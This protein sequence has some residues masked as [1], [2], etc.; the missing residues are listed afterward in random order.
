MTDKYKDAL[1]QAQEE[2]SRLEERRTTLIRLI[3]N[4]KEL[5]GNDAYELTP[6]PGYTPKGL[7]EE[8]RAILALTTVPLEPTQIRD[9]LIARGFEYSSPKNLLINVHTVLGRIEDELDVIEEPGGKKRY[10]TRAKSLH[11]ILTEPIRPIAPIAP[12]QL[13]TR[14]ESSQGGRGQ[15]EMTL[16]ANAK[17]P[18]Q[19]GFQKGDRANAQN[20]NHNSRYR[21]GH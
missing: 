4:L 2:L 15:E 21:S 18:Q 19:R 11:S 3:Q 6:P 12:P 9:S 16:D 8:M 14:L 10:K 17:A 5:S 20:H 13:Y 1:H 7:T